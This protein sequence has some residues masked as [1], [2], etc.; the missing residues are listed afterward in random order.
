[1]YFLGHEELMRTPDM[2]S[3]Y[4]RVVEIVKTTQRGSKPQDVIGDLDIAKV[5]L[6][7]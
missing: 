7:S 2:P 6:Y 4:S 3:K 5:L 1:M